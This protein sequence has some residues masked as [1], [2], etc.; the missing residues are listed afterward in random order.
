MTSKTVVYIDDEPFLCEIFESALAHFKIPVKTFTQP[1]MGIEFIRSHQ[2]QISGVFLDYRIPGTT[3][4]EIIQKLNLP[5]SYYI[6][7]GDLSVIPDL[8]L[9]GLKGI[10][11]KPVEFQEIKKILDSFC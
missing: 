8:Q 11:Q 2:D 4:I 3:G 6:I 7:T 5:L 9:V 1:E 10:L